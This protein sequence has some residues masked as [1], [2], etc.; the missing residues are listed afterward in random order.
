MYQFMADMAC[1][2]ITAAITSRYGER[3]VKALMDHLTR[4]SRNCRQPSKCQVD[5]LADFNGM[6]V[7]YDR[8][9]FYLHDG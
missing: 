9:E 8:A 6:P 7:D 4:L 3:F 1:N 5:M 2:R